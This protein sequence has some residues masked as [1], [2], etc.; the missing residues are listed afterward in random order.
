MTPEQFCYW[1]QGR[2][3]LQPENPPSAEEWQSIREHLQAV[4][5]KVT[6]QL[7]SPRPAQRWETAANPP[8]S[9]CVAIC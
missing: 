5:T 1:L 8:H 4:F 2:A 3:E 7:L 9:T 6:P